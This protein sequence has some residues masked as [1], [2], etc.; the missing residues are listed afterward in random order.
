MSGSVGQPNFD[1]LYKFLV[2]FGL[3][4]IIGAGAIPWLLQQGS[5]DLLVS[6]ADLEELLPRSQAVLER[7][8]GWLDFTSI[9]TPW[10]SGFLVF[11]GLVAIGFGLYG[12]WARQSNADE[13]DEITLETKRL[14]FEKLTPGR[15]NQKLEAEVDEEVKFKSTAENQPNRRIEVRDRYRRVEQAVI[16]ALAIA[17]PGTH[18]LRAQVRF[19]GPGQ[20]FEADAVIHAE[21]GVGNDVVVDIKFATSAE[22]VLHGLGTF[23]GVVATGRPTR[24]MSVLAVVVT[25]EPWQPEQI[26]EV[27]DRA[28]SRFRDLEIRARVDIRSETDLQ[29]YSPILS[30][31]I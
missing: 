17:A 1:D 11:I 18:C 5:E 6:E 31:L 30:D 8:Q 9:A 15:R 14:E 13:S 3:T 16:G 23:A 4:A 26:Y 28:S 22:S 10:L 27:V 20:R 21:Q 7:R 2:S 29:D 12:W 25:K 19:D 24:T